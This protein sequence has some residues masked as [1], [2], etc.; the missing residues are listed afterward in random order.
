MEPDLEEWEQGWVFEARGG[1]SSLEPNPLDCLPR[2]FSS[3]RFL[4]FSSPGDQKRWSGRTRHAL[5]GDAPEMLQLGR[6]W[7]AMTNWPQRAEKE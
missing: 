2:G 7:G 4:S 5:F 1:W 6:T 3:L